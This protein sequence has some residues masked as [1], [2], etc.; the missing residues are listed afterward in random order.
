LHRLDHRQRNDVVAFCH[1]PDLRAVLRG[2]GHGS[3]RS[4]C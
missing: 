1:L 4:P 2:T 3:S